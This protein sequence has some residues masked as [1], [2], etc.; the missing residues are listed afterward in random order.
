MLVS[1]NDQIRTTV[2]FV[3]IVFVTSHTRVFAEIRSV[4]QSFATIQ[5]AIDASAL[6]DVVIVSPGTY[7]GEGN[8]DIDFMGKAI[9]VRSTDPNDP[10]TVAST[11]IDCQN[12]GRGFEF[13]S[14][15]QADSILAGLTIKK[16]YASQGGGGINIYS[17]N[18]TIEK[19][20]IR[21]NSANSRGEGGGIA[22]RGGQA[23][24]RECSIVNNTAGIGG[25]I[26]AENCSP[27][28]SHCKVL[29]N[30]ATGDGGISLNGRGEAERHLYCVEHCLIQGNSAHSSSGGL[31]AVLCTLR[32]SNCVISGNQ[33]VT[34]NPYGG[35]LTIRLKAIA[36]VQHC[37]IVGNRLIQDRDAWCYGGG[38]FLEMSSLNISNSIIR[39]NRALKGKQLAVHAWDG[40]RSF[41]DPPPDREGSPTRLHLHHCNLEGGDQGIFVFGDPNLLSA[42]TGPA[43][44][45]TDPCFAIPGWW[46]SNSTTDALNDDAWIE[47]DYHL[48]SQAGRWN[49]NSKIWVT[50]KVTSPCID[51]GDPKSPIG[52]EPFP[53]G[54]IVNMGATGGTAEASKSYFGE[55]P[56]ET[57]I[58]GDINGDCRVDSVDIAL[59]MEHWLEQHTLQGA[60]IATYSFLPDKSTIIAYC[61][62]GGMR[63]YSISGEFGLVADPSTEGFVFHD[64]NAVLDDVLRFMERP[65]NELESRHPETIFHMSELRVVDASSNEASYIFRKN[66]PVF[67][68]ADVRMKLTFQ[69]D[70]VIL[71]GM[72]SDA[73]V[74][75]CWYDLNALAIINEGG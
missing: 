47:G 18:P 69:D 61:G 30:F 59:L 70:S 12:A 21:D 36:E 17:C 53:N 72:F 73:G 50:D 71:T 22:L 48:Q 29:G 28:I 66:I 7:T 26:Y 37:T 64:V 58:A 34:C 33:I 57:V 27:L 51:M 3:L 38:I 39:Q 65:G 75:R 5:S 49:P 8:R 56:C 43:L 45:D 52:Y 62:R 46:D 74:D 68:H 24:I 4:P 11:I 63:E 40:W 44:L 6:G 13:Q 60:S 1:V 35:G 14:G 54:G 32:M 31:S 2:F 23:T 19:C 67:P 20:I 15:E 9:T 10:S 16:G 42:E 41:D 25:G 55:P